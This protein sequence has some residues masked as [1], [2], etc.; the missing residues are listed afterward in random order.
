MKLKPYFVI[1]S[2]LW[3][4]AVCSICSAEEMFQ[5]P[6]TELIRLETRLKQQ[7]KMLT[8]SQNDL[9]IL[10]QELA[11]SQAELKQA[12]EVL[13]VLQ[14]ELNESKKISQTQEQ[15]MENANKSLEIYKKEM[16]SRQRR[17]ERQRTLAW[18]VVGLLLVRK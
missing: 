3:S 2:L 13:A 9:T 18:C 16:K 15:L 7:D 5:I 4:L 12:K 11:Q 6:K 17:I 8:S 14:A 1:F 10:K